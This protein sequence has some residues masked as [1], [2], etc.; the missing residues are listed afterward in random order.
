MLQTAEGMAARFIKLL[1]E[2][3]FSVAL[4][5]SCT[6]G[7]V[8]SLLAR[9]PGASAVFWGDFVTYT[10][11]AKRQMLGIDAGLL[12]KCHAVSRECACAMAESARS[13]SNSTIGLS[14]T[15]LAGPQGDGSPV[16]VGTV[17]IAGAYSGVPTYARLHRFTGGRNRVRAKAAAAA[18][19]FGLELLNNLVK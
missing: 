9:V 5:E 12:E 6:A 11:E 18:L 3:H 16:R 19:Q 14:I 8:G 7:L 15:G 13:R 4:A 17:W 10:L 1:T 2:K